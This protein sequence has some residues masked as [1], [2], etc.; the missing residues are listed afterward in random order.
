M[1]LQPIHAVEAIILDQVQRW[2]DGYLVEHCALPL[3]GCS[4]ALLPDVLNAAAHYVPPG[5]GHLGGTDT[6]LV[7]PAQII[8]SCRCETKL[9]KIHCD[10]EILLAAAGTKTLP[11]H[12][13]QLAR[14]LNHTDPTP[15]AGICT[16]AQED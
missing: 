5:L 9:L 14:P 4:T 2:V 12:V 15:H 8:F 10:L 6:A 3:G 11:H 16:D 7:F 1:Q 13:L